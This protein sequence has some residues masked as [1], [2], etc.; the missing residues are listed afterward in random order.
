MEHPI[1]GHLEDPTQEEYI[2][3]LEEALI[4]MCSA[5][6]DCMDTYRKPS[7]FKTDEEAMH[8]IMMFPLIQWTMNILAVDAIGNLDIW[9]VS[10]P[11]PQ[12]EE[13]LKA[14]YELASKS[15]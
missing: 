7:N 10:L 2:K 6:S 13:I 1:F 3:A 12:I 8:S 5:Y 14:K 15:K 9:K 4:F 11:M